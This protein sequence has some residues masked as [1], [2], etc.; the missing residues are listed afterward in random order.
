MSGSFAQEKSADRGLAIP[1]MRRIAEAKTQQNA[2][3]LERV[4]LNEITKSRQPCGTRISDISTIEDMLKQLFDR[5]IWGGETTE[6]VLKDIA[7][8]IDRFLDEQ[9]N[10]RE[11]PKVK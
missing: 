8:D 11:V 4:F 6:A 1:A 7:V 9:R 10:Q 2:T 3:G 5:V